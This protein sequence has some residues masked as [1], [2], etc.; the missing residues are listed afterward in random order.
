MLLKIVSVVSM[1]RV[2]RFP[3]EI[4]SISTATVWGHPQPWGRA[5]RTHRH[6]DTDGQTDRHT[7]TSSFLAVSRENSCVWMGS[8]D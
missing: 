2:A 7:H 1:G 4:T 5:H 6:T 8:Q 3:K